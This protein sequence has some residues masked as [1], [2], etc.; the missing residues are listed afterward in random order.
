[1]NF[2]II[3]AFCVLNLIYCVLGGLSGLY[4]DN[5]AGQTVMDTMMSTDDQLE[6]EHEIL[7]LLGLPERPRKRHLHSSIR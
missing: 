1:M 3:S 6:I 5:G 7:E 2:A 4:V